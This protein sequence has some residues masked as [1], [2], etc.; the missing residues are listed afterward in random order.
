M[1]A[2][3]GTGWKRLGQRRRRPEYVK[4]EEIFVNFLSQL[5]RNPIVRRVG[6]ESASSLGVVAAS[7]VIGFKA[8]AAAFLPRFRG[9]WA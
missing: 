4:E 8:A 5:K 7:G 1:V 9:Q 6:Y 3:T 2:F